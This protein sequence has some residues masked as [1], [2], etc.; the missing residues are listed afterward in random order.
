MLFSLILGPRPIINLSTLNSCNADEYELKAE[1]GCAEGTIPLKQQK[2]IQMEKE[3]SSLKYDLVPL[4][5]FYYWGVCVVAPIVILELFAVIILTTVWIPMYYFL[6]ILAVVYVIFVFM[7]YYVSAIKQVRIEGQE[8]IIS[9]CNGDKHLP[10]CEIKSI[11]SAFLLQYY[12]SPHIFYPITIQSNTERI[13]LVYRFQGTYDLLDTL[14][15][16][17]PAIDVHINLPP[18]SI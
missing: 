14:K 4:A 5:K 17:N 12:M 2:G 10:I 1:R 11:C 16:M 13:S 6:W 9:T 18:L 3:N 8:I 15:K 7:Y